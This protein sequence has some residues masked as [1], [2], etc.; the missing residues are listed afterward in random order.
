MKSF[1][2]GAGESLNSWT[3]F[4]SQIARLLQHLLLRHI[5]NHNNFEKEIPDTKHFNTEAFCNDIC[6]LMESPKYLT[7]ISDPDLA[8]TNFINGIK[9]MVTRHTPLKK[10]S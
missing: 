5:K 1:L 4:V 2:T 6:S 8:M 3:C 9:N 10:L 7:K